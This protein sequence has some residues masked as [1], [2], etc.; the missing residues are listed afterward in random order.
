MLLPELDRNERVDDDDV[1]NYRNNDI[2]NEKDQY[3]F[4]VD[5]IAYGE[6]RTYELKPNGSSIAVTERNKKEYVEYVR[7]DCVPLFMSLYC[8]MCETDL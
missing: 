3:Y 2:S 4:V 7:R 8:S 1:L 5:H 6:P